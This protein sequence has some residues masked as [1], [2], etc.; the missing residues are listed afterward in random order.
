M[1]P[2]AGG[3]QAI[4]S[5]VSTAQTLLNAVMAANPIGAV[6]VAVAALAAGFYMLYQKSETFRNIIASIWDWI[7]K[8]TSMFVELQL[9]FQPIIGL[10]RLAYD[11]IAY[12]AMRWTTPSRK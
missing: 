11:N 8:A 5:G 7:K 12:S 6:V 10:F 1:L 4:I 2:S 3:M 9:K